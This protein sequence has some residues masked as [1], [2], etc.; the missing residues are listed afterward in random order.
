MLREEYNYR[1]ANSD[2]DW[3]SLFEGENQTLLSNIELGTSYKFNIGEQ[4]YLDAGPYIKIPIQGIGH[5]N[6][7][8]NTIG[9]RLGIS[10]IK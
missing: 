3:N 10:I 6:V 8:L 7:K 5:G 2:E 1:F 4:L 9:F